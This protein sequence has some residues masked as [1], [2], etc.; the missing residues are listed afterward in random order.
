MNL[1][2]LFATD[3]LGL[4]LG[5]AMTVIVALVL[6]RG[7][8]RLWGPE[9]MVTQATVR[10]MRTTFLLVAA[11]AVCVQISLL[12]ARVPDPLCGLGGCGDSAHPPGTLA[13]IILIVATRFGAACLTVGILYLVPVI[14]GFR[15]RRHQPTS[16]SA[17]DPA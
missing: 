9:R 4:G 14:T 17:A 16:A 1:D 2:A 13:D 11:A 8:G 10:M 7:L 6:G 3:I 5:L 15:W 12:P